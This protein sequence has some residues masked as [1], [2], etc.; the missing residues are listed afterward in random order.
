MIGSLAASLAIVLAGLLAR[1]RARGSRRED[2]LASLRAVNAELTTQLRQQGQSLVALR[3]A[4]DTQVH[5]LQVLSGPH[6]ITAQLAPKG[7]THASG[8][9]LVDAGNGDVALV[10]T[11]LAA[12]EAG[13]AYEL[14]AIRGDRPPEPAGVFVAAASGATAVRLPRVVDPRTVSAFA[15]SIEPASGSSAPTGPIVLV[16]AVAS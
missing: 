4:L 1:E 10:V 3:E 9:V 13:K 15:V 2:E 12:L 5:V 14:W 7:D 6:T 11:E 8:R 16:G